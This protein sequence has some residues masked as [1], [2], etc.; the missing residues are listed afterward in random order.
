MTKKQAT[1]SKV[2]SVIALCARKSGCTLADITSK[3]RI[4]KVA[5]ASLIGDARR[6]GER[7]WR[8][9]ISHASRLLPLASLAP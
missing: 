1:K 6:K 3:L 7:H 2:E 9:C 4:S 5:A 8:F